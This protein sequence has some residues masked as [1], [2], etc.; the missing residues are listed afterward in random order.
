MKANERFCVN[1][2]KYANQDSFFDT[3]NS[4]SVPTITWEE[5]NSLFQGEEGIIFNTLDSIP[6]IGLSSQL[7][8]PDRKSVV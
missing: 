5:K 6:E 4:I 8:I 1:L 2:T 3:L 7:R